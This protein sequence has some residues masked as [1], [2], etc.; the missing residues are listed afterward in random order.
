MSKDGSYTFI[1]TFKSTVPRISNSVDNLLPDKCLKNFTTPRI[2][3]FVKC[4]FRVS[5]GMDSSSNWLFY[6]SS[7]IYQPIHVY[8]ISPSSFHVF[9]IL[10][11]FP[12]FSF[13]KSWHLSQNLIL[14]ILFFDI[15]PPT[16]RNVL[17]KISHKY[18]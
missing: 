15:N 14:F 16:F 10:N 7:R 11:N 5:K 3:N 1:G 13:I 2:I 8:T 9:H 4:W 18:V 6:N 17:L 12:Q